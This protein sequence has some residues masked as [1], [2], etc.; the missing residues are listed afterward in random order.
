MLKAQLKE[1]EEVLKQRE[2]IL[3]ERVRVHL[4]THT[5]SLSRSYS[6][7][8]SVMMPTL[9]FEKKYANCCQTHDVCV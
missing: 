9:A 2:D 6:H 8:F 4:H 5:L 3:S 1:M 7:L